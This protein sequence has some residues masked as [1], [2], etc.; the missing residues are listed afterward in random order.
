M[1]NNKNTNNTNTNNNDGSANNCQNTAPGPLTSD[2]DQLV[3]LI[4]NA[5]A[6]RV[7]A[8]VDTA[9]GTIL[10]D[11]LAFA[12]QTVQAN[13][14]GP[15][16]TASQLTFPGAPLQGTV[17]SNCNYLIPTAQRPADRWYAIIVGR[18]VGWIKGW[19]FANDLT[20][21][22]S[23]RLKMYCQNEEMARSMFHDRQMAKAVRVVTDADD[24]QLAY[25]YQQGVLFP[26]F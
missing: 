20:S 7:P 3:A 6:A 24:I 17:C 25:T 15:A 18:K 19:G 21:S 11:R 2:I 9:L 23:G 1:S 22:V 8:A 13:N 14:N 4:N 10:D 26:C 5:V 12:N 16:A